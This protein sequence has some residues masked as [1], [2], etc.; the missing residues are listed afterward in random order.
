M[1]P[2]K[3]DEK[4]KEQQYLFLLSLL[5]Q[6]DH[7]ETTDNS[8]CLHRS[9]LVKLQ[10]KIMIKMYSSKCSSRCVQAHLDLATVRCGVQVA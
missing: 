2:A 5:L 6:Q 7:T 3:V 1:Q 10:Q 9:E 4:H 8:A